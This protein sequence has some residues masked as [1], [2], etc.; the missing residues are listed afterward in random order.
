VGREGGR[1]GGGGCKKHVFLGRNGSLNLAAIN[2]YVPVSE[3]GHAFFRRFDGFLDSAGGIAPSR[4]DNSRT[5]PVLRFSVC[6]FHLRALSPDLSERQVPRILRLSSFLSF[7][8]SPALPFLY[9]RL[10]HSLE[11]LPFMLNAHRAIFV[12]GFLRPGIRDDTASNFGLLDQIA[13]LLWLRENIAAFGGDPNS[14]TLVGHGTGAIF[15]NL[16]LISPVANKKGKSFLTLVSL[17]L[18]SSSSP[19]FVC[20]R[21]NRSNRS[22]LSVP[23]RTRAIRSPVHPRPGE[24][25]SRLFAEQASMPSLA[26]IERRY[27]I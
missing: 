19:F 24:K 16:L 17:F 20:I 15:A 5:F 1:E 27:V 11:M 10:R 21:Y 13:A 23:R 18:L 7:S 14:V 8:L 3:A 22:I 6:P 26:R 12:A 4:R 9:L 25:P 2:G